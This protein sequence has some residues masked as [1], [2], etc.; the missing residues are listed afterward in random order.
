MIAAADSVVTSPA[1]NLAI[2]PDT[3]ALLIDI[4]SKIPNLALMQIS[5]LIK[6]MGGTASFSESDPT[7][8]FVSVIFDKNKTKALSAA[9]MLE[10]QYPGI[11][12]DIG[13]TGVDLT[14]R[15]A[16]IETLYPD[17]TLY[18]KATHS[19]GFSTRGCIRHCS[20]CVVPQKEGRFR[21]SQHPE[22]FHNPEFKEIVFL[23]NN[24][25]ADEDWFLKVADWCIERS[26]KVDFNQGLDIRLM[27]PIVADK[28][29]K[30]RPLTCLK[31]A[32]DNIGYKD[33][34]LRGAEMLRAAGIDLKQ[35]MFYVYLDSDADFDDA[36]LR[37]NI[38][39]DR[40]ICAFVMINQHAVR[41]QRMT[42]LKRW[43]RPWFFWS[44]P[45]S[46]YRGRK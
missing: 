12:I 44:V 15:I 41:T 7:H 19:L 35:T 17:Y 32:F 30:I 22:R 26:L 6:Q 42:D 11:K 45:F 14:K 23:D 5:T 27:T 38:L 29:K 43:C 31:F 3:R 8:A 40:R 39:R 21:V 25:L 18:P 1:T 20:F 46:E 2:G 33:S 37:C 28:L 34:V 4:D 24:I 13:G 36:L 16:G 9:K 10:F